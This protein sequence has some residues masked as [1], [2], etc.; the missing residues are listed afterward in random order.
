M[1]R[2]V[3]TLLTARVFALACWMAGPLPAAGPPLPR[4]RP[5]T[6]VLAAPA[7]AGRLRDAHGDPLPAGAVRRI[8]SDRY[9]HPVG[10][11]RVALVPGGERLLTATNATREIVLWDLTGGK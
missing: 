1:P 2:P 5:L 4:G 10:F 3:A 9:R 7:R 6:E 11:D 8:G